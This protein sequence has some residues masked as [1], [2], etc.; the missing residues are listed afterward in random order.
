MVAGHAVTYNESFLHDPGFSGA[1]VNLYVHYQPG[2]TRQQ[3]ARTAQNARA[4]G[5]EGQKVTPVVSLGCSCETD[6]H[7]PPLFVFAGLLIPTFRL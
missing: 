3:F 2:L 4:L 5:L 7:A 6:L 1:S